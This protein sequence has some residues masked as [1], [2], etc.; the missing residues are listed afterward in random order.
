MDTPAGKSDE[1]RQYVSASNRIA[2]LQLVCG[3]LPALFCALMTSG[4]VLVSGGG[5]P[6]I[7][8]VACLSWAGF[9]GLLI[10]F[11]P[12]PRWMAWPMLFLLGCGLGAIAA[13]VW[14]V[15]GEDDTLVLT[16]YLLPLLMGPLCVGS[17]QASQLIRRLVTSR[18]TRC[19]VGI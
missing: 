2:V 8:A 13:T 9:F 10:G 11:V 15:S 7:L 17:Y 14:F 1:L 3:L 18:D 5:T 19:A 4:T 6:A 16:A 12:T